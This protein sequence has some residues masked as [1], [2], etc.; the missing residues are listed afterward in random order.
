MFRKGDHMKPVTLALALIAATLAAPAH[1]APRD[2][3]A[4]TQL[5]VVGTTA[6]GDTYAGVFTLQ[7]FATDSAGK[8]V[9]VG[10]LTGTITNAAGQVQASGL[11]TAAIPAQATG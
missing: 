9:A 4:P 7:R 5:P 1:A 11:S 10:T 6:G 8:L 2:P 3:A